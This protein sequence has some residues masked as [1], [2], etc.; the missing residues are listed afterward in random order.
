MADLGTQISIK[1]KN[2]AVARNSIVMV[3]FRPN[4]SMITRVITIPKKKE[5]KRKFKTQSYSSQTFLP[6]NSA[7]VVQSKPS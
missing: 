7:A 6:G 3:F 4:I 2:R 1:P 5:R